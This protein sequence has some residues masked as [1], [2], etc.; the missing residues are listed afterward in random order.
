MRRRYR[1]APGQLV[2]LFVAAIGDPPPPPVVARGRTP[3]PCPTDRPTW[4]PRRARN[5]TRPPE[6]TM[7][8]KVDRF[9]RRG[10]HCCLCRSWP[11]PVESWVAG[12]IM[13]VCRSCSGKASTPARLEEIA[14]VEWN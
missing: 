14:S 13:L 12:R 3:A 2:F 11:A 4:R 6:A 10:A 7:N 1:P 8:R 5:Q 9:V